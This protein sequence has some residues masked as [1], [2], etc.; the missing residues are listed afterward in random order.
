MYRSIY[1]LTLWYDKKDG[2]EATIES[3]ARVKRFGRTEATEKVWS[4]AMFLEPGLR[5]K[6]YR[7]SGYSTGNSDIDPGC[8][9]VSCTEK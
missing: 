8:I 1:K 3:Y 5:A 9:A 4:Q 2:S 6:G 7:R